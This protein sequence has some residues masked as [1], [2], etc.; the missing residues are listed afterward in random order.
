MPGADSSE[1]NRWVIA[2]PA[3]KKGEILNKKLYN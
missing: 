3:G 2:L 1:Q